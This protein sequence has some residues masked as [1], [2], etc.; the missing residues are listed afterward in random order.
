M[1]RHLVI[2]HI[3]SFYSASNVDMRRH[4]QRL[5][6]LKPGSYEIE[7]HFD[8]LSEWYLRTLRSEFRGRYGLYPD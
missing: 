8:T 2:F 3:G 5:V 6:I 7:R 1:P 4:R